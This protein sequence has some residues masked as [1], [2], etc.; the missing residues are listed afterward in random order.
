[1]TTEQPGMPEVWQ[2]IPQLQKRFE[3]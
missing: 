1:M 3:S 2:A